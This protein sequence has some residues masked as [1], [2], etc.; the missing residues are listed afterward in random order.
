MTAAANIV[1]AADAA[2]ATAA[3]SDPPPFQDSVTVGDEIESGES[4][5]CQGCI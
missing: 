1:G 2:S 4:A 3:A 5:I